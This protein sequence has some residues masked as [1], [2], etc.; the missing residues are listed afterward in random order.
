MFPLYCHTTG[1][2]LLKEKEVSEAEEVPSFHK[3][4]ISQSCVLMTDLRF[5]EHG[6]KVLQ[7]NLRTVGGA[8]KSNFNPSFKNTFS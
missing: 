3:D 8:Q 5:W 7:S 1:T 6:E 4:K 2:N